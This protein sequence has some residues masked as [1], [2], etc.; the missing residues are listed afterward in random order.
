MP[1]IQVGVLTV[2]YLVS[3]IIDISASESAFHQ[4]MR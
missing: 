3:M 4:M 2:L 1:Q